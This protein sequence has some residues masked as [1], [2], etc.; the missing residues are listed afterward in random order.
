MKLL[1]WFAVHLCQGD[2][3]ALFDDLLALG[4]LPEDVDRRELLPVLSGVLG[5][6]TSNGSNLRRRADAFKSMSDDLNQIFYEFPFMV[7]AYFALI[8]RAVTVLEGIALEGDSDFD[9]FRAALPFCIAH[10]RFLLSCQHAGV[11]ASASAKLLSSSNA[12]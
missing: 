1:T 11:L 6:A 9:I 4:F 7:P 8:T 5:K 2:W 10:S 3:D 12:A